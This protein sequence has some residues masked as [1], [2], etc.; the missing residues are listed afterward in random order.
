VLT[1]LHTPCV[2]AP[3]GEKTRHRVHGSSGPYALS[4]FSTNELLSRFVEE[5]ISIGASRR[6]ANATCWSLTRG[7]TDLAAVCLEGIQHVLDTLLV[8]FSQEVTANLG[9]DYAFAVLWRGG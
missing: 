8:G 7:S 6:L 9:D 5:T 1:L 3:H 2:R 4:R